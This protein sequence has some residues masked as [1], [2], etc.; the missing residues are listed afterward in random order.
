MPVKWPARFKVSH[1]K[2]FMDP[3]WDGS[4][5]TG[6]LLLFANDD[7]VIKQVNAVCLSSTSN[8][9]VNYNIKWSVNR[10][11]PNPTFLWNTNKGTSGQATGSGDITS[12]DNPN[13]PGGY[14]ISAIWVTTT[15]GSPPDIGFDVAMEYEIKKPG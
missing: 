14:W 9:T 13:V 11:E 15:G 5:G 6:K 2:V 10:N 4:T 3:T 1:T 7:I 8:G 12:F